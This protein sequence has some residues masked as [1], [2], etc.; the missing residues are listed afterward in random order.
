MYLLDDNNL[1]LWIKFEEATE[2]LEEALLNEDGS[3]RNLYILLA[4]RYICFKSL[5]DNS[6]ESYEK[7]R[8]LYT[9]Q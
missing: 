7:Y 1:K 9:K 2:D 3:S 6:V 4:E 8:N 5:I